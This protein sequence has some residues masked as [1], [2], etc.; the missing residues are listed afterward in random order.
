MLNGGA[1]WMKLTTRGGRC[2]WRWKR[3]HGGAKEKIDKAAAASSR[4]TTRDR[5]GLAGGCPRLHSQPVLSCVLLRMRDFCIH[6]RSQVYGSV[7]HNKS[8]NVSCEVSEVLNRYNK[9]LRIALRGKV[10]IYGIINDTLSH[11]WDYSFLVCLT[12]LCNMNRLCS[13]GQ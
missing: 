9:G 12:K 13:V 5:H 11:S 1:P 6:W 2:T 3:R 10:I 7:M 4:M 8:F